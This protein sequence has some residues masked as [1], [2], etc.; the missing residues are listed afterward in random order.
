MQA[1]L[2]I[3]FSISLAL[4]RSALFFPSWVSYYLFLGLSLPPFFFLPLSLSFSLLSLSL[5]LAS[6]LSSSPS[7]SLIFCLSLHPVSLVPTLPLWRVNV[8]GWKAHSWVYPHLASEHS[9]ATLI[10]KVSAYVSARVCVYLCVSAWVCVR[11][12]Q[13]ESG[14]VC[15]CV[16]VWVEW[17]GG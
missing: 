13:R 12:R 11:G 15:A 7:V 8:G 9:R 6:F 4:P 14:S 1:W 17:R 5:S 2:T 10:W 3:A 16:C